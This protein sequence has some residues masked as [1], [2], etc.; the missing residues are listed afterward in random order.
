MF[1]NPNGESENAGSLGSHLLQE[2]G[3]MSNPAVLVLAGD[4]DRMRHFPD[5]LAAK[6][7]ATNTTEDLS[8]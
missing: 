4:G 3:I 5:V 8:P 2:H 7:K 1:D 6:L